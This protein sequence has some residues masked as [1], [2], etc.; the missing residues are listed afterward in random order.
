M[1]ETE[2]VEQEPTD[3]KPEETGEPESVPKPKARAKRV[4][5]PKAVAAPETAV[6]VETETETPPVVVETKPKAKRMPKVKISEV[7]LVVEP[8]PEKP[9][10][11]RKPRVTKEVQTGVEPTMPVRMSRAAKREELFHALASNALP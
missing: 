11:E 1:L 5:K 9:K 7:P 3:I 8:P 6:E 4:P 2:T 10:K